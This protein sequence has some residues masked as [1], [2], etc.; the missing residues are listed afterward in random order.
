[1]GESK[2]MFDDFIICATVSASPFVGSSM[3]TTL[4]FSIDPYSY[5]INSET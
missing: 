3:M 2:S 5:S 1:M 4:R